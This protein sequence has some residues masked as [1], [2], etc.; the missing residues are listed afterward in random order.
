MGKKKF[1][2]EENVRFCNL[3]IKCTKICRASKCDN[4]CPKEVRKLC[5]DIDRYGVINFPEIVDIEDDNLGFNFASYTDDVLEAVE[6]A[7]EGKGYVDYV[8]NFL[9]MMGEAEKVVLRNNKE[10]SDIS[11][12]QI[13]KAIHPV[14]T[15]CDVT[16]CNHC[17]F[18]EK[19][20]CEDIRRIKRL[21]GRDQGSTELLARHIVSLHDTISRIYEF[22]RK[23]EE[24]LKYKEIILDKEN[25]LKRQRDQLV[26]MCEELGDIV[27]GSVKD[28][29]LADCHDLEIKIAMKR[30]E[31]ISLENEIEELKQKV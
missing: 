21:C 27:S 25:G 4:C 18:A 1:T 31:L 22:T 8:S 24:E 9:L 29:S 2:N 30:K 7:N 28:K 17:R 26:R 3:A 19:Q 23:T 12:E 14:A 13:V 5:E 20:I 10:H 15:G 16:G 6:D 11:V